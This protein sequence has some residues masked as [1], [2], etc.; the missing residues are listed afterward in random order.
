M[1]SDDFIKTEYFKFADDLL[2]ALGRR[3][4]RWGSDPTDWIFRGH[5]DSGWRLVP[6]AFRSTAVLSFD[7]DAPTGPRATYEKQVL[8]E[9]KVLLQFMTA[10]NEQ[11][12]E[13]PG[14]ET[15]WT[16]L[17]SI[18]RQVAD[19]A[20]G[21]ESAWPLPR[22]TPHLALA[23][24]HGI[25]TRLL[26]W[27]RDPLTAAYFAAEAAARWAKHPETTPRGADHLSVWAFRK[28]FRKWEFWDEEPDSIQVVRAPNSSNPNLHAQSGLFTVVTIWNAERDG[29]ATL[30]PLDAIIR[31]KLRKIPHKML[32]QYRGTAPIMR[33]LLLPIAQAPR[34]L[35]LLAHES[36]SGHLLFPG[37]DGVVRGLKEIRYWGES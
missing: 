36:T 14:A 33:H 1:Q 23:Q 26:D 32:N 8:A 15:L 5:A 9:Y 17:K 20:A 34:L 2:D 11:G 19:A 6:T 24:H 21:G 10:A 30:P 27:S 16:E 22:L 18:A 37:F 7:P 35:R 28:D 31:S 4:R 25:A 13:I 12:L 29:P 3:N